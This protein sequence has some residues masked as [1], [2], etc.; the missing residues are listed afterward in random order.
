MIEKI[1][2]F[3]KGNRDWKW[4]LYKQ[5]K[6]EAQWSSWTTIVVYNRDRPEIYKNFVMEHMIMGSMAY[7]EKPT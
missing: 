3:K 7:L 2:N 4:K 6:D 1:F 5:V